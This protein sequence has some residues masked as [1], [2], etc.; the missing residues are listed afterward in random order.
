MAVLRSMLL[1]FLVLTSV[2]AQAQVSMDSLRQLLD[3]ESNDSVKFLLL[4]QLSEAAEYSD[5]RQSRRYAND[6]VELSGKLGDWA[7]G[8][9]FLR[10]AFLETMEGDYAEALKYDLQ[11]ASLYAQHKDSS[12]LAKAYID[13]GNDY[14]D[15]GE[16]ADAYYYLGESFRITRRF[17]EIP[18]QKDSLMMGVALHNMGTVFTQLGQ[19]DL[20]YQHLAASEKISEAIK[21][22]LGPAYSRVEVGELFRKKGDFVNAEKNLLAS[23][24]LCR[25]LKIRVLLPRTLINLANVYLDKGEYTK[26]LAYF[27]SVRMDQAVISN[28]FTLAEC[29]LGSG[30]AMAKLGQYDEALKLF[31][32]S[33]ASAKE[34]NAR[35][36]TLDTYNALAALYES[37][38]DFQKALS[39]HRRH[40]GLRDSLFSKATMEKLLQEEVRFQTMN[41]DL[42]IQALSEIQQK[43]FSEIRRQELIQNILVIVAV[44]SIILL[45]TVYRSGRRRKRINRLLLDHQEE[46]K[47][48]SVELEQLNQ[49]KD[50]FFSIISH[51]LR[52]PMNALSGTLD[53]LSR[54][55][56][57]PEE[58]ANLTDSLRTQFNHTRTLISN[59][60]DWTL[61][62]MDKLTLHREPVN[63]ADVTDESFVALKTLYPKN[64]QFENRIE[65]HLM[66]IGDRNIINLILR[67]L[68]LNAIKF[69][70]S[71]GRIWVDAQERDHELLVSVSDTGI[72]IKPEV[73]EFLFT[74]TSSYST[75][76]T[77]NEKGT[78]LGLILCKEFVEKIGGKIGFESKVGEGSTFYF[79]LPKADVAAEVPQEAVTR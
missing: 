35:N 46:I 27:D 70:E 15:M 54:Q 79:T 19:F 58:F 7:K 16:Y 51:D 14:R 56:I 23:L 6:A 28:H 72:G 73:Q 12:N 63:L 38:K 53:L 34:L 20:A 76:G 8:R 9:A 77:A 29:N 48:R 30:R 13:I 68:I 2:F 74:K 39:F 17:H 3:K 24:A 55:K 11:C 49:V 10:L 42:E 50:K 47:R 62:Q 71:G 25:K 5:Y 66:G 75:R 78:G 59:L 52:S 26:S 36:L 57:S 43:Q 4:M 1:A 60:L 69:T 32:R 67:N 65:R 22:E 40:D 21:D 41:K 33:L 64:I 37:K 44:L 31:Q 61:L 45:Y 18:N